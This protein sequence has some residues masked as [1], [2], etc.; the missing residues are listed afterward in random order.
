MP[1]I[2]NIV[3]VGLPG[4]VARNVAGTVT[5]TITA[6]GSS[7]QANSTAIY[8]AVN[9]VTTG[10]AN[11]GVRLPVGQAGDS[12]V[13]TNSKAQTLFI[14]PPVGGAINGGTTDAKVDILTLHAAYC[15]CING[16]NW[17]VVY[18]A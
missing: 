15:V 10:G 8:D 1:I 7:S 16:L 12:L 9:E 14:Y 18:N 11:T 17:G 2:K 13:I 5:S 6:A 3:G 4:P